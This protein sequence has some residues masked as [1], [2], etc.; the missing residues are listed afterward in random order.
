MI[1]FVLSLIICF[2]QVVTSSHRGVDS[3]ANEHSKGQILIDFNTPHYHMTESKILFLL[4]V[5]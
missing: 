5:N 4:L 3:S 2:A 1:A